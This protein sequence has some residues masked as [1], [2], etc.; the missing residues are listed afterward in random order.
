MIYYFSTRRHSYTISFHL[1]AF[2]T[3]L[4]PLVKLLSYEQLPLIPRLDRGT[5]IFSDLDRCNPDQIELA[6]LVADQLRPICRILNQPAKCMHRETLLRTLHQRGDNP[7]AVYRVADDLSRLRFPV[8]VR[9]A[10]EHYGSQSELLHSPKEVDAAIELACKT[11][12]PRDDLLIIE[13]CDTADAGGIFRKYSVFRVADRFI[14]RHV[15]FSKKWVLKF[16]DIVEPWALEEELDFL[17]NNPHEKQTAE[18]FRLANIDYGRIDYSLLNGRL[19]TWEINLNATVM[20]PLQRVNPQRLGIQSQVAKLYDQAMRAI[21]TVP[22]G[23]P[24]K[25]SIPADLRRRLGVNAK[26]RAAYF[27]GTILTRLGKKWP[28]NRMLNAVS[29]D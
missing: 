5:Y 11:G 21:D 29:T 1:D 16:P 24:I 26:H 2:G 13:Y 22:A 4:R 6:S 12:I 8:F 27:G 28:W 23:P 14:A 17:K 15:E 3:E 18:L 19:V 20:P 25:L 7:F 9:R 10:S